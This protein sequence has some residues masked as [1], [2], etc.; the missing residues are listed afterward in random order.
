[1]DESTLPEK[2]EE[3]RTEERLPDRFAE[4]ENGGVEP[5]AVADE[6][7]GPVIVETI[8]FASNPY[9]DL[10]EDEPAKT[11]PIATKV[12]EPLVADE[13]WMRVAKR[14]HV[15][16]RR[17]RNED[18]CLVMVS[19]TG[20]HFAT[21]PF[22]LYIV[23]DGMGGHSDGHIASKIA[24]R[25][26]AAHI[27][28][29]IYL[30]MLQDEAQGMRLP[31]QEVLEQAVQKANKAVF[32]HDAETDSGT[33]LTIALVLGRRLHV[34]HV[35]DSRLYLFANDRFESITND[36]SLVQR[37][38]DVGQLTAEEAAFYR[39]GHILLRAVGQADEVEV[40][41]Y[42]RLL[43]KSGKLLMCS[44]GLSGF[45]PEAELRRILGQDTSLDDMAG[46]LF[47]AA[48]EAGGFDNITA[49]LIDFEL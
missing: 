46:D 16:G 36:H 8:P 33:T 49:V 28:N 2:S 30:P 10:G 47:Q 31:V 24:S 1:M 26:A 17:D 23:A 14:C 11:R 25:T 29:H 6:E 43:P 44:D 20:G 40:D 38:Q 22:G 18:S 7:Y 5:T 42:M 34:A 21:L 15:G 13:P 37:L 19:E 9:L 27:L 41:T 48:M 32:E 35:G 45:V 4:E 39:Y 12:T 3:E